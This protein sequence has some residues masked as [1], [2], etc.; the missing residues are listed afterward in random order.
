M[1]RKQYSDRQEQRENYKGRS[2]TVRPTLNPI[3][4]SNMKVGKHKIH[5][6]WTTNLTFVWHRAS[7]A[8]TRRLMWLYSYVLHSFLQGQRPRPQN[9][10]SLIYLRS[11]THSFV[12][13]WHRPCFG[14]SSYFLFR[15]T[16]IHNALN[17]ILPSWDQTKY[18]VHLLYIC[19]AESETKQKHD[20]QT[21]AAV[22][23]TST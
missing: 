19:I 22:C 23:R 21:S 15:I 3:Q 20:L 16:I 18:L 10:S 8:S 12:L 4:W 11:G 13:V 2:S 14:I 17:V 5:L 9:E 1:W 7:T 6:A